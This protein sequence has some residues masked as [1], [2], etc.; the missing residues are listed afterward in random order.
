MNQTS[1]LQRAATSLCLP[2]TGIVALVMIEMMRGLP[3][4][5]DEAI[6]L[7]KIPPIEFIAI[8]LCLSGAAVLLLSIGASALLR[9]SAFGLAALMALF[10]AIHTVEHAASGDFFV[11]AL[12]VLVMFLPS[13]SASYH[14][15]KAKPD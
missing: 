1:R 9:W 6:D 11:M 12:I 2:I 13:V 8:L 3:A 7:S 15:W 4:A 5:P 10:H 14:I